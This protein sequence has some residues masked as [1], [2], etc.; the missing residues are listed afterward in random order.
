MFTGTEGIRTLAPAWRQLTARLASRRHFHHVEWYL[1]LAETFEQH[2]WLPLHCI[3][4]FSNDGT[5]LAVFPFRF[6]HIQI[7]SIE[8]NAIRLASDQIDAKT[9][10]DFII[11]P[12]LAETAFFQEFV[13]FMSEDD[14]RWDVII[15][16]GILENSFAATALMHSPQLPFFQ[17]PGGFWGRIEFISCS[18]DDQP[19]ERLSKGFRQNLRT[20]H[21]KLKSAPAAFVS[22]RTESS[23]LEFLPEFLK[24]ES[25]GWKGVMG[26]SALKN[27]ETITFL[28]QLI[29]HFGPRGECEIHLLRHGSESIATLFGIVTD[30][31]FYIFRIGYDE[32]HHRASPGH[33]MIENLLKERGS[34]GHFD[35]LTIYNAPSWFRAWKP[36][37]I[38]QIFDAYVFRPSPKGVE[39][40]NRVAIIQRNSIQPA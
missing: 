7:G 5:L 34:H 23:L 31:V 12:G 15:L 38:L 6:V 16:P 19:F 2:R 33:L 14:P 25:S 27:P 11:A 21:N 10:R 8:L 32:A 17:T 4:V 39:L 28:R 22:A 29:T 40:A 37:R 35:T 24:V 9:A 36:D 3:A 13:K 26:T 18:N 20:A 1:A 30:R